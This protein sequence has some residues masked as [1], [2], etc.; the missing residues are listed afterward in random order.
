MMT[1]IEK[2]AQRDSFS[3]RWIADSF[4]RED[5]SAEIRELGGREPETNENDRRVSLPLACAIF[6]IRRPPRDDVFL[7]LNTREDDWHLLSFLYRFLSLKLL[8]YAPRK[9]RRTGDDESKVP[10]RTTDSKCHV[11]RVCSN[12]YAAYPVFRAFRR[13]AVFPID[14]A[15]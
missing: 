3:I 11:P 9:E 12:G 8:A 4:E 13:A 7:A 5:G 2:P 1:I 10:S 14:I 15:V 6:S